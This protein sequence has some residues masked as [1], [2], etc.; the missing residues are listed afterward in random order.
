MIKIA[1]GQ[2]EN[3]KTYHLQNRKFIGMFWR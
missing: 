3:I 1:D 2:R